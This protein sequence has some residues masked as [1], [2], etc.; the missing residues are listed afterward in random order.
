MHAHHIISLMNAKKISE[1]DARSLSVNEID[2]LHRLTPLILAGKI[3]AQRALTKS[4]EDVEKLE[5]IAPLIIAGRLSEF[6]ACK[7]SLMEIENKLFTHGHP[8]TFFDVQQ[9]RLSEQSQLDNLN[10]CCSI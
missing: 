5:R 7:M 8:G 2:N 10:K 9:P 1:A 3:S 4:I 6:G